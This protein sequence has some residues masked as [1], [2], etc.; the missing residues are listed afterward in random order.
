MDETAGKPGDDGE[1]DES[2]INEQE[3]GNTISEDEF[4]STPA[5]SESEFG[6]LGESEVEGQ[7]AKLPTD[8][9]REDGL[10]KMG[11]ESEMRMR[12][13]WV[14]EDFSE[15]EQSEL[16]EFSDEI[17]E[18]QIASDV[19]GLPADNLLKVE[20]SKLQPVSTT[21]ST[22]QETKS[23]THKEKSPPAE[24]P[25]DTAW[26]K[27][28][29]DL[30]EEELAKFPVPV[31]KPNKIIGESHLTETYHALLL[32]MNDPSDFVIF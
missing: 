18:E 6:W 23:V 1:E 11:E 8:F 30:T 5:I 28:T 27:I 29:V 26:K 21:A 9:D 25:D 4:R 20:S 12:S 15:F 2:T 32:L 10:E 31:M 17:H 16:E 14:N 22:V 19:S 7:E 24:L 3:D 13:E